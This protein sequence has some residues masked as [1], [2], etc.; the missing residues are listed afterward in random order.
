MEVHT[1][2]GNTK[3]SQDRSDKGALIHQNSKEHFH[4]KVCKNED[5][6]RSVIIGKGIGISCNHKITYLVPFPLHLPLSFP[7]SSQSDPS[8]C[9]IVLCLYLFI[10]CLSRYADV[11]L[12]VLLAQSALDCMCAGAG[13]FLYGQTI[14]HLNV[15]V[16]VA[17]HDLARVLSA[18]IC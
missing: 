1:K 12:V 10:A 16:T 11:Q 14:H 9:C 15:I 18:W 3:W 8:T 7:S 5:E 13:F 4:N 6:V 2:K 17:H